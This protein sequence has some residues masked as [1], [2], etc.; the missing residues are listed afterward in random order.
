MNTLK[1]ILV[2]DEPRGLNSLK[3]L[4]Q[5]NCPEVGVIATCGNAEEAMEAINSLSPELVFL[6]I[7]MPGK[8]GFDLLRSLPQINFEIIFVTAHNN[9]MVQAFQYSAIDYLLKPVEDELLRDAVKRAVKRIGEKSGGEQV[10]VFMHNMMQRG[11]AQKMKLCIPSIKGFQVVNINEIVYCEANSNYTNIHFI[12]QPTICASRPIHEYERILN[13]ANFVR[14]HK[15]YMVNLEF[16]KE[17][18]RGEGGNIILTNGS[19]IEVSRR[20]KD[21]LMMKMK[22]YFRF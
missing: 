4:L 3:K 1:T 6:D 12:N 17:Y 20:K 9:Y 18:T 11:N 2:D 8:S 15:S 21:L 10:E 7:A 22:E 19:E 16:V 14:V 13:D 5:L